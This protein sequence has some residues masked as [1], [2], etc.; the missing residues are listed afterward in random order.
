MGV[1]T[2]GRSFYY[3][4]GDSQVPIKAAQQGARPETSLRLPQEVKQNRHQT[5]SPVYAL[6]R[7]TNLQIRLFAPFHA[8]CL[9]RIIGP[10]SVSFPKEAVEKLSRL[11]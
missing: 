11:N 7:L 8:V 5:I 2:I 4:S 10:T 1:A 3:R 9:I 6:V